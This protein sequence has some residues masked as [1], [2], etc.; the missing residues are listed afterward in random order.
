MNITSEH[1]GALRAGG[2]RSLRHVLLLSA[3]NYAVV[4]GIVLL[5][6]NAMAL[7][8]RWKF[9][10][11]A[12]DVNFYYDTLTVSHV[13]KDIVRFWTIQLFPDSDPKLSELRYLN[14][15]NCTKRTIR[16]I[17]AHIKQK[18]GK[19]SMSDEPSPVMNIVPDT[20]FEKFHETLCKK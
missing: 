15:I 6:L 20:M 3:V 18:N 13:N 2:L 19:N 12:N 14:E 17:Q 11:M 9:I 10:G 8:A 1:Y 5:A 16:F 7:D 4:S